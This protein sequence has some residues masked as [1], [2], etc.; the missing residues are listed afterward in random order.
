MAS[1]GQELIRKTIA[2][3]IHVLFDML[4]LSSARNER[5][6]TF[7]QRNALDIELALVVRILRDERVDELVHFALFAFTRTIHSIMPSSI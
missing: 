3:P 6:L 5:N 7:L 1:A 2:F 4:E